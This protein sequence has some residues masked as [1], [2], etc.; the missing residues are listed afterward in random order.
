[1]KGNGET[2]SPLLLGFEK[3]REIF[4]A[5]LERAVA[6]VGSDEYAYQMFHDKLSVT[7]VPDRICEVI[8]NVVSDAREK[9]LTTVLERLSAIEMCL[10]EEKSTRLQEIGKEL[11]SLYSLPFE[12]IQ[13]KEQ[14]MSEIALIVNA[15]N[16]IPEHVAVK[17]HSNFAKPGLEKYDQIEALR[18]ENEKLLASLKQ[19]EERIKSQHQSNQ[20]LR[21]QLRE[22]VKCNEEH[23]SASSS[24]SEE[25][26]QLKEA[27]R[28]I[29]R[30]YKI[31]KQVNIE[32]A[33]Q[34]AEL[35]NSFSAEASKPS[36]HE[37]DEAAKHKIANLKAKLNDAKQ[38]A[39]QSEELI[40]KLKQQ[41]NS[42]AETKAELSAAKISISD[43]RKRH[44][45]L[46]TKLTQ[47]DEKVDKLQRE[48]ERLTKENTELQRFR[49]LSETLQQANRDA[50][51]ELKQTKQRLNRAEEELQAVTTA[52]QRRQS[53]QVRELT[54]ELKD[55]NAKITRV[56]TQSGRSFKVEALEDIP[57][58][59]NEAKQDVNKANAM[60]TKMRN[61]LQIKADSDPSV[62]AR[63]MKQQNMCLDDFM[64][65]CG[66]TLGVD[67]IQMCGKALS[68]MK[69]QFDDLKAR[70]SHMCD[71]LDAEDPADLMKQIGKVSDIHRKMRN[72]CYQLKADDERSAT[73]KISNL[74][75]VNGIITE[76]V[77]TNSVDAVKQFIAKHN[78][79]KAQRD[80]VLDLLSLNSAKDLESKI[81]DMLH[82]LREYERAKAKLNLSD[83]NRI[84]ELSAAEAICWQMCQLLKVQDTSEITPVLMDVLGLNSEM[85][86]LEEQLMIAMTVVSPE[87]I[88]PKL[89]EM[90][91]KITSSNAVI[92]RLCQIVDAKGECDL[93]EKCQHL[94]TATNSISKLSN[95]GNIHETVHEIQTKLDKLNMFTSEL[96]EKLGVKRSDSIFP[97]IDSLLS[98]RKQLEHL[99]DRLESDDINTSINKLAVAED[100][101]RELEQILSC[102]GFEEIKQAV[103][104]KDAALQST[105]SLFSRIMSIIASSSISITF[106]LADPMYA[107]LS[108]IIDDFKA[109]RESQ[110]AE[111][112]SLM[113]KARNF[114]YRGE[115]I[116][117]AVDFIVAACNDIDTQNISRKM[118]D[119]LMSV[120]ASNAKELSRL[121][122]QHSKSQKTIDELKMQLNTSRMKSDQREEELCKLLEHERRKVAELQIDLENEHRVHEEL[123]LLIC[124]QVH[125][126]EILREKLSKEEAEMVARAENALSFITEMSQK[127]DSER[128][129]TLQKRQREALKQYKH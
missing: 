67:S 62:E 116:T 119:D 88:L 74:I 101:I 85:K 117:D 35:R 13:Q 61:I 83:M 58:V 103:Q 93:I 109:T 75:A 12:N 11:A 36:A 45:D 24:L 68:D 73:E 127:R 50:Q 77:G 52:S 2:R 87:S 108:K 57:R 47:K 40:S 65:D 113:A 106:P 59:L 98:D 97:A 56:I 19:C 8:R 78:D 54:R 64:K 82:S 22:F 55:L 71:L 129:L 66:V 37:Q 110:N 18:N 115:S 41:A 69:A 89:E 46:A 121:E 79:M 100:Y 44:D 80:R 7:Y 17:E 42:V 111:I 39:S 123:M 23:A 5:S 32:Y 112:G 114:G 94:C 15:K 21:E 25:N 29:R 118:H 120:R 126:V 3:R 76:H 60:L 48:A 26:T 4:F 107:R 92:G 125:D 90:Q 63:K 128:I 86:E 31:Q 49:D 51:K 9:H 102:R 91:E 20:R 1:M 38:K 34:I 124:G 53:E 95:S 104:K 96:K 10:G 105:A 14:L 16:A 122:K 43:L 99:R 6:E 30:Q 70:E 84:K 33:Q 81:T 27:V 72:I 28:E